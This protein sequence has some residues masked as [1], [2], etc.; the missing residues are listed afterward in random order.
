M[1]LLFHDGSPKGGQFF[2]LK[3][4]YR[5]TDSLRGCRPHVIMGAGAFN[6][7]HEADVAFVIAGG[8]VKERGKL[9]GFDQGIP[10]LV[11]LPG[12]KQ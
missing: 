4:G 2:V 1:R 7:A 10:R 9:S 12:K 8:G 6:A 5:M 11:T 3:L